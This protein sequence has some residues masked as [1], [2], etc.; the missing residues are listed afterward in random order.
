MERR[1]IFLAFFITMIWLC[2]VCLLWYLSSQLFYTLR[3]LFN[4]HNESKI[5]TFLNTNGR[6]AMLPKERIEWKIHIIKKYCSW[7]KKI[8]KKYSLLKTNLFWL[9]KI[10][11]WYNVKNC[12][13]KY[14][15]LNTDLFRSNKTIFWYYI[16]FFFAKF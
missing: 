5:L 10:I 15:L 11:F 7:M 12:D 16:K 4:L 1:F 3:L 13:I 2:F 6:H 14:I 9:N 8:F